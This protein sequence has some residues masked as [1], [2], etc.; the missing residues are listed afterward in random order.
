MK[1]V[2]KK[3]L[4]SQVV[5]PNLFC[6]VCLVLGKLA[7]STL[8]RQSCR[9]VSA[10]SPLSTAPLVAMA[11]S[12]SLCCTRSP[13]N[14]SVQ[15]MG[16]TPPFALR[17]SARHLHATQFPFLSIHARIIVGSKPLSSF[18][19]IYNFSVGEETHFKVDSWKSRLT[20]EWHQFP[21]SLALCWSA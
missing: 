7:I 11:N 15:V 3:Q 9:S 18:L 21:S 20:S 16:S 17:H 6:Y 5:W 1:Q 19:E 4:L 12:R 13:L 8:P 14:G 2:I 10:I